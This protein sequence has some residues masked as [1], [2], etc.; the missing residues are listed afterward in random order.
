[1]Y[2]L[3]RLIRTGALSL[4]LGLM[5]IGAAEAAGTGM[6]WEQPLQQILDSVQGPVAGYRKPIP[7]SVRGEL[8]VSGG[9]VRLVVPIVSADSH[10][11][12]TV[13]IRSKLLN[14]TQ[15]LVLEF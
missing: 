12:D 9:Y 10:V 11:R 13:L 15:K 14:E 6:P 1:M 8:P 4:V 2:V 7:G 3:T 5:F